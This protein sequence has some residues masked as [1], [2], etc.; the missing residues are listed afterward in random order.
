MRDDE[1][2]AAGVDVEAMREDARAA[3]DAATPPDWQAVMIRSP[4]DDSRCPSCWVEITVESMGVAALTKRLERARAILFTLTVVCD[5]CVR[6]PFR[7]GALAAQTF[8]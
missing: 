4:W 5:R 2:R 3:V 1:L 7:L 8:E 6:N